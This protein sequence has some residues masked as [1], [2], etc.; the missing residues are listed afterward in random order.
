M[1][2]SS[3]KLQYQQQPGTEATATVVE[4]EG[5][6]SDPGRAR[7]PLGMPRS[8]LPYITGGLKSSQALTCKGKRAGQ[9]DSGT[10]RLC[11]AAMDNLSCQGSAMEAAMMVSTAIINTTPTRVPSISLNDG[12]GHSATGAHGHTRFSLHPVYLDRHVTSLIREIVDRI[13]SKVIAFKAGIE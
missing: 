7:V 1:S 2:G 5:E 13:T 3:S 6:T 9:A 4:M 10:R 8:H 12:V 11:S